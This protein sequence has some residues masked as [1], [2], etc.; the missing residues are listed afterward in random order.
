MINKH[1]NKLGKVAETILYGRLLRGSLIGLAVFVF[2]FLILPYLIVE[3]N[4]ANT[5]N[6]T[7]SWGAMSIELDPDYGNGAIGD[8]NHGDV[9]FGDITPTSKSTST[10]N[11][12]TMKILKKT[13][14]VNTP[15]KYYTVFLSMSGS[16]NGLVM[17]GSNTT[18]A[19]VESTWANPAV[20]SKSGWGFAVPGT[21]IPSSKT[22]ATAPDFFATTT[23]AGKIGQELTITDGG[24]AYTS[25]KWAAV[26]DSTAPQQIWKA[27]TET[28][29]GFGTYTIGGVEKTGDTTNN[30]FD[31]YYAIMV[32]S[33]VMAGTY[34]N[35]ITYTALASASNLDKVSTNLARDYAFGGAGDTE[36][37]SFDLAESADTSS[38][39]GDDVTV[40]L[41]PHA[42]MIAAYDEITSEYDISELTG[43]YDTCTIKTFTIDS[44]RALLTCKMPSETMESKFDFWV[45]I[46]GYNYNYVSRIDDGASQA[47]VYAG[48]QT[49]DSSGNYYVTRMQEMTPGVCA[50][51]YK[52]NDQWGDG[53]ALYTADG[54]ARV[55]SSNTVAQDVAAGSFAL[56]DIR[57]GKKYLVRRLADGNC[58]MTQNLDLELYS[59]MTLTSKDTDINYD[60]NGTRG[61]SWTLGSTTQPGGSLNTDWQSKHGIESVTITKKIYASA[62]D[63]T[64]TNGGGSGEV[65]G[66]CTGGTETAPCFAY[67]ATTQTNAQPSAIS[68][69][70]SSGVTYG[71]ITDS[72]L[73]VASTTGGV[74]ADYTAGTAVA[75]YTIWAKQVTGISRDGAN[76]ATERT[77]WNSVIKGTS[78][79]MAFDVNGQIYDIG[80]GYVACE[81]ETTGA[82]TI[83]QY[84]GMAG[85]GINVPNLKIG[86]TTIIATSSTANLATTA[87]DFRWQNNGA[88]GAH[89]YDQGPTKYENRFTPS[90]GSLTVDGTSIPYQAKDSST[91]A[92]TTTTTASSVY[93]SCD[94][95]A[96]LT[97]S[98]FNSD[99]ATY[100]IGTTTGETGSSLEGYTFL[101]CLT[102]IAD[103]INKTV[104]EPAA[105]SGF[106]GNWYNWYAATAGSGTSSMSGTDAPDSIC[107]R[108]WR[109][110]GNTGTKS[111]AN[112]LTTADSENPF[113]DLADNLS[114][115][116]YNLAT[117]GS[118]L[119]TSLLSTPLAFIRSGRY[120]YATSDPYLMN[121]HGQFWSNRSSS[122]LLS[123]FGKLVSSSYNTDTNYSKNTGNSVR[124]VAR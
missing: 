10:G 96:T 67:V 14:G 116:N 1:Q 107:P 23:V 37:I 32:D 92:S 36:T 52:W 106:A 11:I 76:I 68:S 118:N 110:P 31:V 112:L 59:S 25:T 91:G 72:T 40:Y 75:I 8:T 77:Q 78:C 104:G 71:T 105:D 41:V 39:D 61:D 97:T 98:T 33:D 43:T 26:P 99:T 27:S 18:I 120:D 89:V 57:D 69:Q 44:S 51:T 20:F 15:G 17:S 60:G 80:D 108:G 35:T 34:S 22:V 29:N 83:T 73:K 49:K 124:C 24:N 42:E 117:S 103:S 74:A 64:V 5:V 38:I 45:N 3:A 66:A 79:T 88:D 21:S 90:G 111:F 58:W 122:S 121:A 115:Y 9:L 30:K 53:A 48:L 19:A 6:L 87:G 94:G 93:Q 4:A 12:G 95:S 28:T 123:V 47:Y 119:D 55:D 113:I 102:A 46:E 50:N 7:I 13:I 62:T 101:T 86:D 54:K 100:T 63:S 85:Y 114:G 16:S 56:K 70:P 2:G 109:L 84:D 65:T 81:T 82:P